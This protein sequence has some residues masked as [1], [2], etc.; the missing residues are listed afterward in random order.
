V[1]PEQPEKPDPLQAWLDA[2]AKTS[3]P[4][5]AADLIGWWVLTAD[6]PKLIGPDG[7]VSIDD[8]LA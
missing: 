8:E 5:K 3:P 7:P 6:G 1:T 2:Q 4:P